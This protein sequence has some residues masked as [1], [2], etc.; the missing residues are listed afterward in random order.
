MTRLMKGFCGFV[1]AALIGVA[2][3]PCSADDIADAGRLTVNKWQDAVVTVQLVTK[4]T[5]SAPGHDAQKKEDKVDATGTIID[6]SG[7]TVVSLSAISP[8][9][10]VSR[11]FIRE[12]P[13]VK[14]SS[15]IT[16]LKLI[17]ADGQTLPGA[18]VLRDK[19]LDLAFIRPKQ[20]P[21]APL[22][23]VDLS[24]SAKPGLLDH[25]MI[26]YR[27]GTVGG[28]SLAASV[29]RVQ[30]I[31]EKPRTFYSLGVAAMGAPLGAPVFAMDSNCVG[32]LLLR[33]LATGVSDSM[34]MSSGIGGSGIMYVVLPAEDVAEAAKQAPLT[35][36][37]ATAAA[38]EPAPA[39]KT[40][41]ARK[42]TKTK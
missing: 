22:T 13:D 6:P 7:L 36:P 21:A 14:I 2:A 27:L 9:D 38:V 28:R 29:D 18:V 8:A 17:L 42:T 15:D 32:I 35:A 39:P 16:D 20:K 12:M 24:K 33:V 19:D 11:M 26:M 30:S 5:M 40:P 25:A 23:A 1:L 37:A 3:L 41:A 10:V 34:P 31:I 4:T